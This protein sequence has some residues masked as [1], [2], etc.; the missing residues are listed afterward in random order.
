MNLKDISK[1]AT[2][3]TTTAGT[4][5]EL[6]EI[7]TKYLGRHGEFNQY[8]D[9]L[10]KEEK[11]KQGA[12]FN[13]AKQKYSAE[14]QKKSDEIIG[15]ESAREFDVT[16]PGI[17]PSIGH[18]HLIT[19]A[20]EEITGIFEKIGFIRRRYPEIDTDWYAAEG[21]NIPKDHPARDDQETFYVSDNVVLTPH[22]S[23][24]QLREME[25]MKKPPIKMINIGKTYRR[26]IDI[27]HTPMFHQFEG[28]LI[29]KN[30][31]ITH[32]IGVG[33]YFV[34][35]YF[36]RDRRIRLRPHHFQFTEPSF[37]IDI[38]CGVCGG[39]DCRLCKAGW[40][41]LGGAGMVHPT[42]L[43]NGGIDPKKYSGFAFGWGVERVL[44][45]KNNLPD[46]RNIYST[47]LRILNQF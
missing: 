34:Q 2:A 19:G 43:K 44:A 14:V 11:P 26:Q 46:I 9:Q 28:L 25:A 37:E 1:Q 45:M 33:N 41:E 17:L 4:I 20:I 27:S 18:L 8:F 12:T 29:D 47:D 30:I 21:L 22:T 5:S 3:G 36:G 7:E 40:L 15:R 38:T 13:L 35:H 31:D 10:P 23:N 32:L 6:K 16:V 24:G 42:V 39:L